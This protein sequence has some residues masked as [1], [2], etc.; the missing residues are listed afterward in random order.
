MSEIEKTKE[1]LLRELSEKVVENAGMELVELEYHKEGKTWVLRLFIDKEGGVTL[2]DCTD[3]S[4]EL[5]VQLDV[6]DII[7]HHYLLEVS[8]P[9]IN[10]L[11]KKENDFARSVGKKIK[12][13][14]KRPQENRKNFAGILEKFEN[15]MITVLTD[16]KLKFELDINDI[17]KARLNEEIKIK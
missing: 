13:Q 5:G 6:E 17:Q 3:I 14:M 16:D 15:G 9:G 10:R 7:Q 8:S 1:S 12:V 4:K 11:L 2:D